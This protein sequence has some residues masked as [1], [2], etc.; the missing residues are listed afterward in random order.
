MSNRARTLK[1]EELF[2]TGDE[3]E[4]IDEE[5][6]NEIKIVLMGNDTD[7]EKKKYLENVMPGISNSEDLLYI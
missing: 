2:E 4:T 7:E 3:I 6:I 5:E 1:T